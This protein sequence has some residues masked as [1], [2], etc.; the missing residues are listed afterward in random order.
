MPI[1]NRKIA[2]SQVSIIVDGSISDSI[3][4]DSDEKR[5]SH[6]EIFN[7]FFSN[8]IYLN[9][10]FYCYD[11]QSLNYKSKEDF[12]EVTI[13]YGKLLAYIIISKLFFQYQ[14]IN[15]IGKSI[16]CKIIKHCLLELQQLKNKLNIYDLINNVILIGGATHLNLDKYQ[17]IF[18]I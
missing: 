17:I 10:D 15:L 1:V 18:V 11:W 13:F 8:C 9:S 2:S 3:I 7:S 6:K 12:S 4:F 5:L 14:T 16:R